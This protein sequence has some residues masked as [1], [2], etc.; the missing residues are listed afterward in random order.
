M[1]YLVDRIGRK[2]VL[3]ARSVLLGL[4]VAMMALW[5]SVGMFYAMNAVFGIVQ[6][7]SA[8]GPLP[9]GKQR[10]ARTHLFVQLEFGFSYG[11]GLCW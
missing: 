6:C 9:D 4:A 11:L 10:R 2:S 1:G 8:V 7:I 5:P 3:M